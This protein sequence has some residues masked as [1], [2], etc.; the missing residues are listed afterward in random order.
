MIG[1]DQ[2]TYIR[3]AH[4]VYGKSIKQIVRET[5]HARNTIRK[6]LKG[7]VPHYKE[8]ENQVYPVLGPYCGIIDQWLTGDKTTPSGQHHTA[9]RVYNR[10]GEEYNFTG[11]E[12]SVRSYVRKAR[13]RLGLGNTQAYIPLDPQCATEAEVDWGRAM[14]IMRGAQMP[15][16]LF[17]MRS[18]YS[19]KDFVRAYSCERQE[20]FFDGHI[21][22][23]TYFGG[24][25]RKIVYDNLKCAV[26]R[27][28]KGKN[29]EEQHQF[30]CFRSYYTFDA[31][32]CNPGSGHEKG[33]VEGTVGFA[34]RNYCVPVPKVQS[35][36]ELNGLLITRCI[37]RGSHRIAGRPATIDELFEEEKKKLLALPDSPYP[38][39]KLTQGR[40]SH[41][42][43]VTVDHNRY[44]VPT[45]YVGCRVTV[46]RSI[47][48]ITIFHDHRHI[49]VHT[50][51]YG[52]DKWILNPF[53]YLKLL[54]RKPGA[55]HT[56]RPIRQWRDEWPQELE[57]LLDR[58]VAKHGE[59]KGIKEFL[60]VLML[61]KDHTED[62][63]N[64]VVKHAI[65]LGLAD[66]ASVKA[67]LSS[68]S[69]E[70]CCP[71][72]LTQDQLPP[73][74]RHNAWVT[75]SNTADYNQLLCKV[76]SLEGGISHEV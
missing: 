23:F 44:S 8:R 38:N 13:L 20:A 76:D 65:I 18:R 74:L 25:F 54:Q 71:K 41:Y 21:H 49:A 69:Q 47:D 43:T 11:S 72:E 52:K 73:Q 68:W 14:V 45:R 55:F 32:F 2:Y 70:Q 60:W 57:R 64:E 30:R 58:F 66:S 75:P 39:I 67:L 16:R 51:S 34:R 36:D 63:V 48:S 29:R 56:A 9:R 24:V 28:L 61:Y 5:G 35:F 42:G 46:E 17:C 53:H 62:E 10:L 33:G 3:T 1:M 6:A 31:I 40:V 26:L 37:A 27:I 4:R 19:G 12:S 15:V 59:S 22:A 7:E 50:R